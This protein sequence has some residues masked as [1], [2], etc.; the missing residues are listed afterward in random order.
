MQHSIHVHP[1]RA[2]AREAFTWL[3]ASAMLQT[4]KWPWRAGYCARHA[5]WHSTA[6][7]SAQHILGYHCIMLETKSS[8]EQQK[9]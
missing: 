4:C 5:K 1:R 9:E 7:R 6:C 3:A 8:H 2:Q